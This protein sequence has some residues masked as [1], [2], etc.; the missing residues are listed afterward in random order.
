MGHHRHHRHRHR[1][2]RRSKSV[3]AVEAI[4]PLPPPVAPKLFSHIHPIYLEECVQGGIGQYVSVSVL[5]PVMRVERSGGNDPCGKPMYRIVLSFRMQ[6][7]INRRGNE[8][9]RDNRLFD[10][11]SVRYLYRSGE[12]HDLLPKG[13][14]IVTDIGLSHETGKSS[15]IEAGVAGFAGH[16]APGLTVHAQHASKLTYERRVASWRKALTYEA[17]P[18]LLEQKSGGGL[19]A[20]FA[21]ALHTPVPEPQG[22]RVSSSHAHDCTCRRFRRC[23]RRLSRH[24]SYDC[25]AHW[26]GQTEAQLHLWTPEIYENLNSPLTVTREVSADEIDDIL[27]GNGASSYGRHVLRK[28]L[29]FDFDVE[30]RLRE[31]GRGFLNLFKS[32]SKPPEIRAKSEHGK[33]LPTD[34]FQFCVTCCTERIN[35]PQFETRDLQ[36]EAEEQTARHGYVRRLQSTEEYE[37]TF[38]NSLPTVETSSSGTA[39]AASPSQL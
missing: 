33:P 28:Y 19:A 4:Q 37:D 11:V 21:P 2:R 17:Y 8:L 30:V 12:K 22:F 35:W 10:S 5:D 32:S 6:L 25:A 16:I 34:K 24:N 3:P 18:P 38:N 29:H 39:A 27:N 13:D 9:Q 7:S 31:I 1:C 14:N 20:L 23:R 15:E 26:T 36:T